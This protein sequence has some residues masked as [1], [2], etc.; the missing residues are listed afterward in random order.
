MTKMVKA[1]PALL[2]LLVCSTAGTGRAAEPYDNVAMPQGSY[3]ST[4]PLFRHAN[5]LMDKNGN[6][7]ATDPDLELYQNTFKYTY[8]DKTLLPK[9][10]SLCTMLPVSYMNL[11]GDHDGGIGDLALIAGYWFVDDP[12]AKTW[13]GARLQTIVPIGSYDKGSKANLGGN[14]WQFRPVLYFAKQSGNLQMELT[15][16][17][18][19]YT[20]NTDTDT[21]QGHD[22]IVEGYAG[23]FLRPDLLLGWQLNGTFGQD[24]TVAGN[25]VVDSGGRIYQTG[26]SLFKNFGKG[27]SA[28]VEALSDFA[29]HNSTEGYTVLARLS[30][31]I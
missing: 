31:K 2:V 7:V 4:Y 16:K 19:I 11:R 1:I 3:F 15:M 6:P 8:Y 14:V 28:T 22:V 17:Y 23:W 9:T 12:V 25:R 21:R 10:I 18:S 26:P 27:F 13:F 29:V 20:T 30:W 5:R 24:K